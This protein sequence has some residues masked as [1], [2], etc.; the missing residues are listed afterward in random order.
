M[1]TG[2]MPIDLKETRFEVQLTEEA[3]K[4]AGIDDL[5]VGEDDD[6]RW[7]KVLGSF[8]QDRK[9]HFI[10]ALPWVP[11]RGEPEEDEKSWFI[12]FVVSGGDIFASRFAKS[13]YVPD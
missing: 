9:I 2:G 7:L 11:D 1:T 6:N 8:I 4:K 3:E 12:P 10:V 13:K 5:D